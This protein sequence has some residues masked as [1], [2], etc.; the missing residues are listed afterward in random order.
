MIFIIMLLSDRLS[1]AP[2]EE[3]LSDDPVGKQ[4]EEIR[5]GNVKPGI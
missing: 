2:L 3:N 4:I 1:A 5:P